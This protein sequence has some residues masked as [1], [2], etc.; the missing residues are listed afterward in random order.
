VFNNNAAQNKPK[1]KYTRGTYNKKNNAINAV[2]E[3]QK[4][5]KSDNVVVEQSAIS[6]ADLES[7]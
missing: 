5:K 3:S 1:T 4:L 7:C 2:T 6:K